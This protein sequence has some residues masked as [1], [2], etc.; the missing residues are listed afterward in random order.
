MGSLDKITWLPDYD[1][2]LLLSN[3]QQHCSLQRSSQQKS[4]G[5]ISTFRPHMH[6]YNFEG[7]PPQAPDAR[8]VDTAFHFF[9]H[10]QFTLMLS[11]LSS[12]YFQCDKFFQMTTISRPSSRKALFC[13]PI[14]RNGVQNSKAGIAALCKFYATKGESF[15]FVIWNHRYPHNV[16]AFNH[17]FACASSGGENVTSNQ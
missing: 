15:D 16:Q 12:P 11:L 14:S 9:N 10:S 2:V 7:L 17:W 13:P 4:E 1:A 8:R 6:V 5:R 3:W